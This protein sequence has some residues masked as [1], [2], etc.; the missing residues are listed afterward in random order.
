[1]HCEGDL[2]RFREFI[3]A[4]AIL[5]YVPVLMRKQKIMLF[6]ILVCHCGVMEVPS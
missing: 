5:C 4:M 6:S 1:M 3:N 2:M